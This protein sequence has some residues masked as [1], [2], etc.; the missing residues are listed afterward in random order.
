MGKKRKKRGH[1]SLNKERILRAAIKLADKSGIESVSM[2]SLG[3]ALGVEAMSLYNHI[4]NK[5]EVL[6]GIIDVVVSKIEMPKTSKPKAWKKAMRQRAMSARKVFNEHPWAISLMDS[7]REPGPAM[8]SYCDSVIGCLLNAGF[9][10]AMAAHAYSVM[11]SYIYGFALQE[12]NLPFDSTD[13]IEE[14]AEDMLQ[15]S[16]SDA[17]PHLIEFVTK[18]VLKPGYDYANE[19][20]YGLDLILNGLAACLRE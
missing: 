2:R 12:Q 20:E 11:D 18:H 1:V 5:D 8:L 16:S 13:D 6:T 19:F 10:I 14:I 4:S 7:R 3:Q 15:K 9:S 17:Y